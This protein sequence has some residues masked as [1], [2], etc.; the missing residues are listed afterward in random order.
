MAC[1]ITAGRA[2][3]CLDT[4]GGVDALYITNGVNPYGTITEASDAISNMSG[5]FV[6]FKYAVN[7]AGNSFTT[8]ATVNKDTGTTFFSTVISITLPKMSKEDSA[9]LKLMAFGRNSIVIQDRNL[10]AFLIGREHGCTV[11]SISQTSGDSRGDMSGYVIEL[12]A[13]EKSSPEFINGATAGNPFA[14]MS[15]ASPTITVVTNS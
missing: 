6:A 9:Q 4:L 13:E 10:N 12:L 2:I 3:N 14:G 5:T 1:L 8:T 11:Q 7:G 15:S